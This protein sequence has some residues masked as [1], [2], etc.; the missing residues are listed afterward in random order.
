MAVWA[1]WSTRTRA[2]ILLTLTLALFF[3]L[4]AVTQ[5]SLLL[6]VINQMERAGAQRDMERVLRAIK[7]EAEFLDAFC[8]DWAFWDDMHD[9]ARAPSAEFIE[10]NFTES[11]TANS[12]VDVFA[13]FDASGA[14]VFSASYRGGAPF[15]SAIEQQLAVDGVLRTHLVQP[16]LKGT[17]SATEQSRS[18]LR[19]GDLP[20]LVNARPILRSDR[21]GPA[22]GVLVM[23]R[24]LNATAQQSIRDQT[25]VAF[26]VDMENLSTPAAA[27]RLLAEDGQV[28][29]LGAASDDNWQLETSLQ[30]LRGQAMVLRFNYPLQF[31]AHTAQVMVQINLLIALAVGGLGLIL[32]RLL[33]REFLWPLR[34]LAQTVQRIEQE[35]DMSLRLTEQGALELQKVAR[36]FNRMMVELERHRDELT[37]QSLTDALTNLPNRRHFD[38]MMAREWL[39]AIRHKQALTVMLCDVDQF[40]RYNDHY[41]HP[42]GD[43]ILREVAHALRTGLRRVGDVVARYGGEEFVLIFPDTNSS[44]ARL[45]AERLLQAVRELALAHGGSTVADIVTISIGYAVSSPQSGEDYGSALTRADHALYAAKNAGRNTYCEA[46]S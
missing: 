21:S 42:L 25:L 28:I 3:I 34:N 41:G 19:V 14:R 9:F 11:A 27:Q 39:Q 6:P 2:L 31:S 1:R 38:Q 8:R 32:F 43:A 45:M 22:Q 16:I 30:E 20:M 44:G 24:V 33:A 29:W 10:S 13:V 40:K 17:A 37:V 36:E 18:I 12:G 15:A 7:H 4:I 5:R 35:R 46:G 23:A 26:K